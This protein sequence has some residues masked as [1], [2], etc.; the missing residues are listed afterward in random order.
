MKLIIHEADFLPKNKKDHSDILTFYT[1]LLASAHFYL[2]GTLIYKR[3]YRNH[4]HFKWLILSHIHYNYLLNLCNNLAAQFKLI[5]K[6]EHSVWK[7]YHLLLIHLP[8]NIPITIKY[9][10]IP[11]LF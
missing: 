3:Q 9:K 6:K 1:K 5:Y 2:D 8:K 4:P 11:L 10:N 7:K